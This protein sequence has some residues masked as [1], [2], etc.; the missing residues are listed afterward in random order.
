MKL[1]NF[2]IALFVNVGVLVYS[3]PE[4]YDCY[5]T[6]FYGHNWK[7]LSNQDV[8]SHRCYSCKVCLKLEIKLKKKN[9]KLFHF[10]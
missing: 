5:E 6:S 1:A 4:K 10:F 3:L 9:H 2:I 8:S 7:N